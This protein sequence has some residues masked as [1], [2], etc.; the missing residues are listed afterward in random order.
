MDETRHLEVAIAALEAQRATLS[1][2]V[3]DAALA[4]LRER[5]AALRAAGPASP[6]AVLQRRQ[7]TV[8]FADVV[9]STAIAERLDAEDLVQLMSRA[10]ERFSAAVR[11]HHG[12]VLRYTGDGLKAAFGADATPLEDAPELAVR[13]GLAILAATH[14]FAH[15]VRARYGLEHFRI[16][17]GIHTGA[18]AL[19][20][21]IEAENTAM[22]PTVN[23][24]AR[25]E[26]AAPPNG[27]RISQATYRHVRGVFEISEEPPL[28][29]RGLA[30]PV[31]SYLVHGVKP[32]AFRVATR[33]VEGVETPMIGRDT[34]LSSLQADFETMSRERRLRA[35][36]ILGEAGLGK[37]R[38]LYEVQDWLEMHE[39]SV[40]LLLG[41][42]HPHSRLQPYGLL[43]DLL[44]WRLQID[45]SDSAELARRKLVDGLGTVL[46]EAGNA[47]LLGQLIGLDFSAS[48]AVQAVMPDARRLR[49]RAFDAGLEWLRRLSASDGSPV[50][51]L[52]DD[53]HWA[54]DGSLEFVRRLLRDARELPLF[55]VMLARPELLERHADWVDADDA[56]HRLLRLEPM[57]SS[58]SGDLADSLLRPLQTSVATLHKLIVDG[59][60]GNPFYMEELVKMLIDDGVIVVDAGAGEA[61][62]WLVRP[63]RLRQARVPGT[64]VGVLQARLAALDERTRSA[65]QDASVIGH[66]FWDRALAAI[67]ADAPASLDELLRKEMTL[68]RPGSSFSGNR[69]YAFV[70]HL[71]H[72]VTYDGVLKSRRQAAHARA[73]AWLAEH[74]HERESE[75]LAVTAEHYAR[76]GNRLEA[77][78]YFE[79]AARNAAERYANEEALE[80]LRRGLELV[81][82]D[83][84][85]THWRLLERQQALH[86]QLGR[87]DAME[88]T[89]EAQFALAQRTDAPRRLSEVAMQRALLADRRSEYDKA[90]KLA[91]DAAAL[92]ER[93]EDFE[94]ATLAH[95]ECVYASTVLGA[96]AQARA[97]VEIGL[98]H[99]R[100][101]DSPL[102]EAKLLGVWAY[103]E[104]ATGNVRTARDLFLRVVAIAQ[105]SGELRLEGVILGNLADV[106]MHL[107]EYDAARSSLEASLRIARQI[108][109]RST[110][111]R[112][113]LGLAQ[114]DVAIGDFDAA[115]ANSRAAIEI[116]ATIGDRHAR[117]L[118]LTNLAQALT[119]TGDPGTAAATAREAIDEEA[120]CGNQGGETVLSA[121]ST[122]ACAVLR[123]G[124]V[125]GAM[126]HVEHLLELIGTQGDAAIARYPGVPYT[127]Y[128]V[129]TAAG[130]ARAGR[131][132]ARAHDV[133][134]ALA[135]TVD[136][137]LRDKYLNGVPEH[138]RILDAWAMSAR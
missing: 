121:R 72:Q 69:E 37:S 83:D 93:A 127:C 5:I 23:L 88:A 105:Q 75:F 16:R 95:C 114:I 17:V 118:A 98:Q 8:L 56:A 55:V 27:L 119:E 122:M 45:D 85:G 108:E 19:G 73:A 6:A 131:M 26:Q 87:Y 1:D 133:L 54:D 14:A 29:I 97:S 47:E 57:D 132:L 66:V 129:L 123:L 21:G 41:R 63:D 117:S 46:G 18:V 53:L 109:L 34:E 35:V 62:S 43:R 76:A 52:L 61:T 48:P 51:L 39:Q 10:L 42:S 107:G 49:D 74:L 58:V 3:V 15:D 70:H 92:A 71:L 81:G 94:S 103:L 22:G 36:S 11:A 111:G 65:L 78:R 20:A 30:E 90:C 86:D 137:A 68:A 128:Q 110:E 7:V 89:L 80:H 33:G 135:D 101:C 67:D 64:L 124:D 106:Q 9:G 79:R 32:R 2:A 31:R 91:L 120:A 126:Q 44:A 28:A 138:R 112:A 115:I 84:T 13:A 99:A 102:V 130:D 134:L 59:A 77:T 116:A 50:V 12:R 136:P 100:R 125:G 60:G 4:P 38:L 113:L 24:A 82:E 104:S 40:W 96:Y 25:L